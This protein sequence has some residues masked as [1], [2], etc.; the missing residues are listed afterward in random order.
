M[1]GGAQQGFPGGPQAASN[2]N[3]SP[4]P[5]GMYSGGVD[6]TY[7]LPGFAGSPWGHGGQLGMAVPGSARTPWGSPSNGQQSVRQ[8][9]ENSIRNI[10][11]QMA[12]D[13]PY[14]PGQLGGGQFGGAG[15]GK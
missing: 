14:R 7:A 4:G 6:P 9:A 11:G 8:S 13:S 2:F 10:N 15:G 12:T 5:A 1:Y 3:G